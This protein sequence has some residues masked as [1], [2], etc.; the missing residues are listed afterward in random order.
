[1]NEIVSTILN[2]VSLAFSAGAVT[3]II[4]FKERK[5]KESGEAIKTKEEAKATIIETFEKELTLLPTMKKAI[6]ELVAKDV[7]N[8]KKIGEFAIQIEKLENRVTLEIEKKTFAEKYICELVECQERKPPFG[9]FSS[10]NPPVKM[11]KRAPRKKTVKTK[12][13]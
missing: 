13:A 6:E 8:S 4:Y 5:V 10:D 1:M 9:T 7:E 2:V 3:Y 11:T 12:I